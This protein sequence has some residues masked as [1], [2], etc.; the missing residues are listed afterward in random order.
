[1]E[2]MTSRATADIEEPVAVTDVES[3]VID[4]QHRSIASR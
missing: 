1:V 3:V 2:G 4:G